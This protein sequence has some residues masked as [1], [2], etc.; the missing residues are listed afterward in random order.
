MRRA[1]M[2]LNIYGRQA[3]KRAK[4][5]FFVF[6]AFVWAYVRQPD[7]HIGW[8]TL[9]PFISINSTNLRTNLLN[10]GDNCLAF[11]GVEK[12]FFFW[13]GHSNLFCLIPIQINSIF[14][15]TMI[16]RKIRGGY[17]IMRHTVLFELCLLWYLAQS[18]ILVT[19]L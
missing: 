8:V 17:R 14:M 16:S 10:F 12:L 11:S 9:M 7:S 1:S 2:W 19:S 3:H 13:V 18:Q 5:A 15:I 6:L 4:T